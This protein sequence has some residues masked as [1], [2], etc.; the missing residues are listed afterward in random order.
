MEMDKSM[1]EIIMS[2]NDDEIKST[3]VAVAYG[4]FTQEGI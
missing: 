2:T 3:L 1:W 4:E